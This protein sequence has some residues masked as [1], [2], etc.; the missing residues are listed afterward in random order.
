MYLNLKQTVSNIV[1]IIFPL[2]ADARIVKEL[3]LENL[4]PLVLHR[5]MD[6]VTALLPFTSQFV[7]ACVHEVKYHENQKAI[8]LL[9]LILQQHLENQSETCLLIPIP[10]SAERRKKRG[11]N[12][13][14]LILK[15]AAKHTSSK[16]DIEI[17]ERTKNTPPQTSLNKSERIENMYEAFA[18]YDNQSVRKK[19]AGSTIILIDDVTTTGATLKAAKAALLPHCPKKII[20]VALAH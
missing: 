12:Q 9:G 11:Y 16:V 10:L 5:E 1:E 3:K 14:E 15:A 4:E 18:I 19:I 7:R 17:L 2:R 8:A 6:G 13:T 20:C